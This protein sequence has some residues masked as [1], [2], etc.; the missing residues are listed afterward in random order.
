MKRRQIIRYTA[1]ASGAVLSAPLMSIMM[2][3]CKTD[4]VVSTS[5]ELSLFSSQEF[6]V[7]KSVV[8]VILPKT[9]SPSASDVGVHT[10]ID[11]MVGKVFEEEDRD[12]FKSK[13]DDLSTYLDGKG[14]SEGADAEKLTILSEAHKDGS[15][16]AGLQ[17]VKQQAIAYYLS[18][19]EIAKNYLNYLPVPGAWESCI[20]LEEAGGKK[21]AI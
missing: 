7:L 9:D 21:W 1:L 13:F 2:S 19:E 10:M 3:G 11:H 17:A 4:E 12:S 14:F 6:N 8:D 15:A 20:S 16:K 5:T 18:S